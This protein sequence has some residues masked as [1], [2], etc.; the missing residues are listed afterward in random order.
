[1]LADVLALA[2]VRGALMATFDA[3]APW[4]IELPERRGASFHAVVSGVCWFTAEGA[5]PRQLAPGDLVLLPTGARHELTAE[6]GLPLVRFDEQ[7][8]AELITDTGDLV[9]DGPGARTRILCAGYSYDAEVAQP[10]LG[11]LPAVL[12]I[13]TTA[14][15]H[16]PHLRSVLD[17]LAHETAASADTG[18]DTAAARLLDLLLIHVVRTWL[19]AQGTGSDGQPPASWLRGLR[20]PAT[21]QVLTLLHAQPARAWTLE[22]LAEAAHVSRATLARRFT[23]HVGEPPLTYLTRWRMDLAARRLRETALPAAVIARDVGYT[24]EYAFNRA[25]ARIRG[26]PPGRYRHNN[27]SAA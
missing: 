10:L 25:F 5:P 19:R 24:S 26:C 4:G 16:G 23:R 8:K 17:L 1:M 21:A 14:P 12:H 20:D 22:Q 2:Q 13:A 15:E 3:R 27:T 18:A 6:R 11:L 7:L 9:L